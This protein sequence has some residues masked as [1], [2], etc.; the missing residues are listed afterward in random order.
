MGSERISRRRYAD[1]FERD[2]KALKEQY[3][4]Q[5]LLHALPPAVRP[6]ITRLHARGDGRDPPD[7]EAIQRCGRR[8]AYEVTELVDQA[9]IQRNIHRHDPYDHAEWN[10]D[11][12]LC[13]LSRRLRIK[14]RPRFLHGGPYHKYVLVV[15]TDEPRLDY[16]CLRRLLR[17][18]HFG[19]MRLIDEAWLLVSYDKGWGCCPALPLR[20]SRC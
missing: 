8:I 15:H 2:Q 11:K 10:R 4:V 16:R 18:V 5:C 17:G 20:L 19:N 7:C 13:L 3:V 12:L 6:S 1:Y 14:D 9:A